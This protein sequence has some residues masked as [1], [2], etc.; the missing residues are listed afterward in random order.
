[1]NRATFKVILMIC[2]LLPILIALPTGV[3][4]KPRFKAVAFDYF[5]I[6]DPASVVPFVEKE[7]PGKGTEFTKA[8]QRKQFE[9]AFLRSITGRYKDFFEVTA[10][11]LDHTAESMKL[12]MT[13]GARSRL[14]GSYLVLK[15]WP[16]TVGA[17]KKLKAAG[18]RIVAVSNFSDKMLRENADN[19]GITNLF[20]EL[21]STAAN[22]KFK[23]DPRA[24]ELGLDRLHLEKGEIAF[25]AFGS[26]DAY[27][28]KSFG[29]PTFWVN[30]L[31]FPAER[32]GAEPDGSSPDLKGFLEFVLG[33]E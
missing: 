18:V 19:A 26:W 27:G 15:P 13:A 22:G 9:Y 11:A 20:D 12:T 30:R 3:T 28:A 32:L 4:A 25:A 16:D 5:V 33:K 23:P 2:V 7:F 10:D 21:L 17:L 6:F 29:Y 31:G 1:M 24:Y 14:L 8:W